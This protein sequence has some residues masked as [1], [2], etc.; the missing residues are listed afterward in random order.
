MGDYVWVKPTVVA[1]V[2]FTEWT[3]G[4]VL[5]HPEFVALREDKGRVK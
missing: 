2:K 4:S 5:R 1:D 3:S